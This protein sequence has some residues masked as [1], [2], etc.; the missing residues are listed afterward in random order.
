M[1]FCDF[2]SHCPACLSDPQ[3]GT[4]SVI[5]IELSHLKV[6]FSVVNQGL[7]KHFPYAS[8]VWKNKRS[9]PVDVFYPQAHSYGVFWFPPKSIERKQ[10]N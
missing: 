2:E 7:N 10:Y 5:F 1:A 4:N 8:S 6:L 3:L 9:A